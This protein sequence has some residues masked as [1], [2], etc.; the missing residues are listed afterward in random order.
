M[1]DISPMVEPAPPMEAPRVLTMP[2]E[3]I[4]DSHRLRG[5]LQMGSMPRRLVDILNSVHGGYLVIHGGQLDDPF[6]RGDTPRSLETLQISRD[7]ILFIMPRGGV[8]P[9]D[10]FEVVKKVSGGATIVVPGFDISGTIYLM[11]GADPATIPLIGTRHFVP[12]TD[13]TVTA[14][15]GRSE[16]WREPVVLV[17]LARALVYGP[18]KS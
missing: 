3:A 18:N 9:S 10:P 5:E 12:V 11:P 2:V 7:A 16:V 6:K 8:Q 17:N 1:T 13:A 15:D 4:M 14:G